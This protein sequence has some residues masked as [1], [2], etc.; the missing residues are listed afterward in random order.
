[1]HSMSDLAANIRN[2]TVYL[3][4]SN[5]YRFNQQNISEYE[6]DYNV[7]VIDR[8]APRF[9]RQANFN[10]SEPAF[11][12][13]SD[14]AETNLGYPDST[15]YGDEDNDRGDGGRPVRPANN[16]YN[17]YADLYDY[18]NY[19]DESFTSSVDPSIYRFLPLIIQA[20]SGA[21][22]YFFARLACKLCMQGF[23]F[24]FPLTFVTPAA[25][26]FFLYLCHLE[27][28]TRV[29]MPYVDIGYWKC[30]ESFRLQSFH[31]QMGCGL[32]LWW[33]SQIWT[34]GYVWFPKSERLAKVER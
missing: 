14:Y 25:V 2:E 28:W 31:W 1:M 8:I 29:T 9:R 12:V 26:G 5:V 13:P 18:D 22:A 21:L 4:T 10:A 24:S 6:Y 33:L 32:A 20:I 16:D 34:T 7:N 30:S 23:S 3:N 17:D 27:E 11:N 19:E 15:L